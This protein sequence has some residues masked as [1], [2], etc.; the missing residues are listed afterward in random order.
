MDEITKMSFINAFTQR[1]DSAPM[2]ADELLHRLD[3]TINAL[4]EAQGR[5]DKR[6]PTVAANCLRGALIRLAQAY[7]N[8]EVSAKVGELVEMTTNITGI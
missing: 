2:P 1:D 7:G 6:L 3:I 4:S 5:G 8:A